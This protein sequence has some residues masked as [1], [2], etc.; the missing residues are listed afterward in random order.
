MMYDIDMLAD[1]DLQ[2]VADN[3]LLQDGL[4]SSWKESG[5]EL[6]DYVIQNRDWILDLLA[7]Q[8]TVNNSMRLSSG[9]LPVDSTDET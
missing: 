9:S 3:V 5:L 7:L 4:Y 2:R 6:E 8:S 1:V